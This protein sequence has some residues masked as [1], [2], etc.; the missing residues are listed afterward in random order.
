MFA[1]LSVN[2]QAVYQATNTL[3]DR[4]SVKQRP[5]TANKAISP[6]LKPR[7]LNA[8]QLTPP[9]S[10][11]RSSTRFK[12][13]NAENAAK[14]TQLP[15]FPGKR[16]HS[17]M[18]HPVCSIGVLP[19]DEPFTSRPFLSDDRNTATSDQSDLFADWSGSHIRPQ[20]HP[21]L[22]PP[23]VDVQARLYASEMER[24]TVSVLLEIERK[25]RQVW[26]RLVDVLCQRCPWATMIDGDLI[27]TSKSMV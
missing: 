8:G 2:M 13:S 11:S 4:P 24:Q 14:S 27:Q 20:A 15:P 6:S 17:R 1:N 21:E 26:K 25:Q 9:T 16:D 19:T 18:V 12:H 7:L 5:N 10:S 22:E 23:G 3:R